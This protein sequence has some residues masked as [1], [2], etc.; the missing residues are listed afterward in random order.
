MP[1]SLRGIGA[2]LETNVFKDRAAAL[3]ARRLR[4]AKPLRT[5]PRAANLAT[6]HFWGMDEKI[7]SSW[8]SEGF[9]EAKQC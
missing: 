2:A 7:S 9:R 8:E 5:N 4:G 3:R 6:H 1:P